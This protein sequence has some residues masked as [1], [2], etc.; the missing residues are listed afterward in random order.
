M[1]PPG[2]RTPRAVV[3]Y[4]DQVYFDLIDSH[5]A[6]PFLYPW[7]TLGAAFVILYLLLDHRKAPLLKA[8]RWSVFG[9]LCLFQGWCILTNRARHHASAFGVGLLS[10]WGTLW[11]ASI[12]IANDCQME[13]K[14]IECRI[15]PSTANGDTPDGDTTA[16]NG[17]SSPKASQDSNLRQRRNLAPATRIYHN[18]TE[19]ELFWQGFPNSFFA[20][21]DWV[22]DAFCSFRG[23]G[24]NWQT[25]GIPPPPAWVQAQLGNE[26]NKDNTTHDSRMTMSRTGI[27]RFANRRDLFLDTIKS[28]AIAYIVLDLVVT[29]MHRDPYFYG[30]TQDPGPSY[31]YL[32]TW[33]SQTLTQIY[34][35]LLSLTGIYIA[36]FTIFKLG[37]L[38]FS[39]L[40]GPRFLGLRGEA[41]QNPADMFGSF[42]LVMDK[43]LA[44]WWG[45]WWH[46]TFRFGFE[47]PATALLDAMNIDKKSTLGRLVSLC[48][49]FFLSGCVHACGSFTQLGDTRP[50]MGPMR[51]FLLQA[52]AIMVQTAFTHQLKSLCIMERCPQL[53][54]Q[55]T[56]V[57][58][59]HVWLY[60]TS[61]LLI[62]DFAQGGVWLFEPLPFSLLRGLGFGAPD[63]Q[64]F[65]WWHGLF[66][67]RTGEAWFDTGIAL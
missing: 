45:G 58:V 66:W 30:Y 18:G 41:W 12:M 50:L 61:P 46:Q 37:P 35:R 16:V 26:S 67:W 42:R 17:T 2:L 34:R 52:G 38:S 3:L 4:Y 57:V 19:Y 40:L 56:N 54:R 24:W 1:L 60:Y 47:A 39:C 53:L 27:R 33:Q 10:F 25:S 32:T 55:V 13:F 31:S 48:I 49:A 36:L 20:R 9:L 44:G 62:D 6:H 5:K 21:L 14:R 29:L 59:V 64:F 8:A 23:V 63:D 65:A 11:V 7:G 22:A 15:K 51:F 43:G 28:I